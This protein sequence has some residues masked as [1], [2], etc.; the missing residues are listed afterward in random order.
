MC[1]QKKYLTVSMNAAQH[2]ILC[3]VDFWLLFHTSI[4]KE[5]LL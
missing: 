4:P 3:E 5:F 1:D 2:S